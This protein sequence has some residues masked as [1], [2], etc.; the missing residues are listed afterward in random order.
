[1]KTMTGI[2]QVK[3]NH[4][5]IDG[6]GSNWELAS[7]LYTFY[8]CFDQFEFSQEVQ[9]LRVDLENDHHFNLEKREVEKC[10]LYL[11]TNKSPGPEKNSNGFQV[12]CNTI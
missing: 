6:F 7:A 1:M 9:N 2:K 3:S 8:L 5:T 4:I 12:M 10:F 11:K